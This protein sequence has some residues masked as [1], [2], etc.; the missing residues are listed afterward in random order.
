MATEISRVNTKNDRI[1]LTSNFVFNFQSYHPVPAKGLHYI[2]NE[3]K[4]LSTLRLGL[5]IGMRST[6]HSGRVSLP[7]PSS[8]SSLD[9]KVNVFI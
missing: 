1:I 5:D 2:R 7:F 4:Y 8:G 3:H 9:G 6:S